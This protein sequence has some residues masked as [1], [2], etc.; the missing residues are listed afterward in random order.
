MLRQCLV[1][2]VL[3]EAENA[4][5]ETIV[6]GFL[7]GGTEGVQGPDPGGCS[8]RKLLARARGQ[9]P[10]GALGRSLYADS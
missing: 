1:D 6:K 8:S 7:S 2:K 3:A 5:A 10:G 9:V 4:N